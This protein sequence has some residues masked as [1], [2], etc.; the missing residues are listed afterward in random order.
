M[1]T[2]IGRKVL[3]AM[4]VALALATPAAATLGAPASAVD[5]PDDPTFV[6]PGEVDPNGA[7]TDPDSGPPPEPA[8]EEETADAAADAASRDKLARQKAARPGGQLTWS[9]DAPD[10][11][12]KR[13]GARNSTDL[14]AL[15]TDE[16]IPY[17]G[18][19]ACGV[20]DDRFKVVHDYTRLTVHWRQE[21]T[22]ARLYCGLYEA[23]GSTSAFG[24][25]HIKDRHAGD[26]QRKADYIQRNWRDLAG[27]A[28]T[29]TFRD[30]G[31]IFI[32]PTRFCYQRKFYLYYGD[33][34]VS[35]MR[36]VMYLGETGVR[37][38]TAYPTNSGTCNGTKIWP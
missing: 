20:F 5:T 21:R 6:A 22:Y 34:K 29:Y 13:A 18:W 12:G 7:T 37:I 11:T 16:G 23:D 28:M 1:G 24:Y 14:A 27:W 36:A 10:K 3:G 32:Q 9:M 31:A 8:A 19:A 17:A 25:R 35:E 15:A 33:T 30:P 4:A 26:W 2:M 38:M